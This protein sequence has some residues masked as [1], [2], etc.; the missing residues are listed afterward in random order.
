MRPLR[1][2]SYELYK[3]S[4]PIALV[5]CL[6]LVVLVGWYAWSAYAQ[7][8]RYR[9]A[10][11][12]PVELTRDTFHIFLH[13]E[14][15]RDLRRFLIAERP[16]NS[17]LPTFELSLTREALTALANDPIREGKGS[18]V[19]AYLRKDGV[20]EGRVRYRGRR[21]WHWLASQKSMKV[22]VDKGDLVDGVRVFNLIN[23]VTPFGL[24]EEIILDLA[25]EH[26]LLTPEY[27]PVWVRLN[28]T[29]MG[30]Y[31]YEAQ[32]A[33][34]LIRRAGRM[35]GSIYSGNKKGTGPQQGVGE[36]FDDV[37]G[38]QKASWK[39]VEEEGDLT[40]LERLLEAVGNTTHTQFREF[41]HH[42]LDLDKL[43]LFDALDVVFGG[44]QHDFLSNHKYLFDAYRGRYEPIAWNFR[45]FTHDP[46]FNL[47]ENPMLL[48]L[49]GLP[50][51]L[52]LRDR[53]VYELLIGPASAPA[54]RARVDE[55]FEAM[56]PD[57]EADPYWDA[58]KLLARAS[59]FHRFMVRPMNT[60][61]WLLAAQAE[62]R[63]YSRRTRF[64]LNALEKPRLEL[65]SRALG[66]Q[67]VAIDTSVS[68]HA[69][70]VLREVTPSGACA[71]SY[72]ILADANL[73][74]KPDSSDP[75][76]GGGIL[77]SPT[78]VTR[79]NTLA[80]GVRLTARPE[81]EF[82]HG[83]VVAERATRTY[84]YLVTTT[85]CAPE[86]GTME[87]ENLVTGA[88]ERRYFD[89]TR[90]PQPDAPVPLVN[91]EAAHTVPALTAGEESPHPWSF[92]P[93]PILTEVV[94]G[95]GDVIIDQTRVFESHQTVRILAGT[96]V[97]LGPE[98]SLIFHGPVH[99]EGT[100]DAPVS[101]TA[102]DT[103]ATFGGIV[104]LGPA[105]AGS[106]VSHLQIVGGS[107]PKYRA[108]DTPSLVNIYD[109]ADI[110]LERVEISGATESDDLIH[111][112]YVDDLRLHE[113]T[114]RGAPVD[115]LDIEFSTA[116]VRGA[117]IFSP[118]DECLDL[119]GSKIRVVDSLLVGCPNSAL[120]A[121]EETELTV[122]GVVIADA[123]VGVL[124]KNS[125]TV[126]ISRS[127]VYRSDTALRTNKR[128]VHYDAP[129]TID[130][131]DLHIV[132]CDK[133][134]RAAKKTTIATED[135]HESLP[136]NGGLD[137]L[138]RQV[139]GLSDWDEIDGLLNRIK[140][141]GAP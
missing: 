73:N 52:W 138:R 60:G 79:Y 72:R 137:Y 55:R 20:H 10:V 95:P 106:R 118:G 85:G 54:I 105:T 61:R 127:M 128:D 57:L 32:P 25:R 71:G 81:A 123:R 63:R 58:Y 59:Q 83:T 80:P 29:D 77:G 67:L 48:R 40:E 46:T 89:V 26:G 130:A 100:S 14:L 114:L 49:K 1:E 33:E 22:R 39:T 53:K 86:T 126:R 56:R 64:L 42:E 4:L 37:D 7:F 65:V 70:Y 104:L 99:I 38:W 16:D 2:W 134:S 140:T 109:T 125:S 101:I 50:E 131:Q 94:I 102:A 136:T 111:A 92:P 115:A 132:D 69:A 62:L 124:S 74:G 5:L 12:E 113:V 120:S 117:R 41:A 122:H 51:Y 88:L 97:V 108:L 9:R 43:A 44:D 96:G 15:D 107:H 103:N 23:D 28:N 116:R 11:N 19:A 98:T 119:M 112:T 13:D 141:G 91:L 133:V 129:S 66:S 45:A 90:E 24:E 3:V 93:D 8:D 36:L 135:L 47:V 82:K 18:Y 31:R 30:V 34:G 21:H 78:K 17:S 75:V 35:P 139:L 68:G 121:G 76:V 6:P 87:L 84:R 110:R 27:H